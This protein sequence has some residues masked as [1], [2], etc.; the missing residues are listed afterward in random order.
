MKKNWNYANKLTGSIILY[1]GIIE[2]II[3]IPLVI[4]FNN[5]T[6]YMIIQI[7]F[8]FSLDNKSYSINGLFRNAL[9]AS[10]SIVVVA[11][12]IAVL[13]FSGDGS[14]LDFSGGRTKDLKSSKD[15]KVRKQ[16]H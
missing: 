8:I 14:G 12:I 10:Y 16:I 9:L 5:V 1:L 4:I 13:I 11:I 3:F 15:Q 7:A 2:S 6:V